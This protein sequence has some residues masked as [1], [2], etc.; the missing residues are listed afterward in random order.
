MTLNADDI[1]N[2]MIGAAEGAFGEGWSAVKIYAP[3]EFKKMSVQLAEIAKNVAVYQIDNTQGYSPETGKLLFQMQRTACESVLVAVT[4][5]TLLA[6]QNALNAIIKVL[7]DTFEGII[8]T[9]V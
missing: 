1:F 8:S 2:K 4:H 9:I 3:A 7:K 5:L 6:V